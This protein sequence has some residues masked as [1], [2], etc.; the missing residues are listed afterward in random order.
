MPVS[1]APAPERRGHPLGR[2]R[3]RMTVVQVVLNLGHGGMEATAVNLAQGLDPERFRAVIVALDAGGEH[4]DTLRQ[5][6]IEYHVLGG[7]RFWQP[8]FHWGLARLLRTVNAAVVHTHH[9]ASLVHTV[10]AVRLARVRRV[11]HTEH[12]YQYLEPRPDYRRVLRWLSA[13]SDVF[14]VV[15]HALQPYYRD[16]VRVAARRLRVI[17][18]GIDT[19]RYRPAPDAAARRHALGLPAAALLVGTAGRFFPEKDY[20]TLLRGLA[21]ACEARAGLH[22][23]LLGDGP[24]RPALESLAAQLGLGDR[25][26]FLGWRTDLPRL[27][28][29]LDVF[30]LSSRSEALPLVALEALACA[31]PVVATPVGEVPEVVTDGETGVLFPVGDAAA[32]GRVLTHL[33]D[34]SARRLALGRAGRARVIERYSQQAMVHGYVRAYEG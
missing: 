12:S 5:S 10:P 27:L 31:V 6:G 16:A 29:L 30:V 21:A 24:E 18:N 3:P 15:G 9:F 20:A 8:G 17:P 2:V 13:A 19:E 11:I 32:L 25:V 34:A 14:V 7:R 28:P 33:A 22:L 4:E 1:L 23:L 26:S